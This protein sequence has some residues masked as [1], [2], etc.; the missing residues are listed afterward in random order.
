MENFKINLNRPKIAS[1]EIEK[2]QNFDT[3]LSKFNQAK[4]PVYKNPWFW[5]S[6]G[7]AT[8]GLTTIISLN[9]LSNKNETNEKIITQKKSEL[10]QD[11]ECIKAPLKDE[12]L[13]FKTYVVDSQKDEK[14]VL[15]SGTSIEIPKGSLLAENKNQEVEIK[16]REFRDKSSAF[17]AGI[18]MDY[19]NSSAFESAGMIEIRGEQNNEEVKINS[20]KPI[21]IELVPTQN[22]ENFGFWYLNEKS[23]KWED[24][25]IS[26]EN[27]SNGTN[28]KSNNE[29]LAKE[30]AEISKIDK[31]IVKTTAQ[32]SALQKPTQEAYKIPKANAKK[33]DLDFDKNEYPELAS[34]K[35]VLFE[36]VPGANHDPNFSKKS[37][38]DI[39][40]SKDGDKYLMKLKNSKESYQVNV[41]PILKGDELK[42]AENNF[43]SALENFKSTKK[44]LEE[45]KTILVE[46]KLAH[47]KN[48]QKL[49]SAEQQKIVERNNPNNQNQNSQNNTLANLELT[50]V[51]M[52]SSSISFQTT[53][54]GIFN[55]DRPITY[56]KPIL[57]EM[58]I[59]WA[60]NQVAKFKNIFVFNKDKNTRFSY[61]DGFLRGI[62][63]LGFDKNNHLVVIGIDF[64]GNFGY[65]EIKGYKHEN[66]LEK[67]IFTRK[68]KSESSID[69]LKNLLDETE[70]A[71]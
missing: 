25:P 14:I 6:A 12:N 42:K 45:K 62:D 15:E 3:V 24:Y 48:L 40:L 33:Y 70:E 19:E 47:E 51:Q 39:G 65:L 52:V 22:P 56:P 23:K 21:K 38:S 34:F 66:E 44:E 30:K 27:K 31:E 1:D 10:P 11:T 59:L 9:A 60:G 29:I 16:I 18:P 46:D 32:I 35:D 58:A 17:I 26:K 54:F 71:S 41:R 28:L 63:N 67:L 55:S 4:A 61:G 36:V 57:Y 68:E 8:V 20:E 13:A 5:G 64:D 49:I 69:L 53:R 2:N 7:L 43:E 37:W 50:R